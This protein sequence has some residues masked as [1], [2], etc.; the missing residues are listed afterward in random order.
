MSPKLKKAISNPLN[1]LGA[2]KFVELTLLC[3]A[4]YYTAAKGDKAE[5]WVLALVYVALLIVWLFDFRL[6]RA[7][8]SNLDLLIRHFHE[9]MG[10]DAK[11][12]VRITIHKKLSKTHYEQFVDYYPRGAK[13]GKKH[14]IKKGIVKYAFE[15]ASGEFT[16]NFVDKQQKQRLLVERYNFR[17]EEASQQLNDNEMSYYCCPIMDDGSVWGVLYMNATE[18]GTFPDQGHITGTQLSKSVRVLIR[19]IEHEVA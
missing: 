18:P 5:F 16:E 10:F 7:T 19:F 6:T 12:D 13:S 4:A 15:S 14:E 1:I 8:R 3:Y 11:A 2:L 17:A 9:Q